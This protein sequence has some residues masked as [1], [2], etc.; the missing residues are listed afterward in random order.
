MSIVVF[1]K[2]RIRENTFPSIRFPVFTA[3]ENGI[4]M[5]SGV[6]SRLLTL[7]VSL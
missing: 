1:K 5:Y 3:K 2:N 6:D 7:Y 4:G